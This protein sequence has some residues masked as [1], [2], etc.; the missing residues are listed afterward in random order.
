[1]PMNILF[2]GC[3]VVRTLLLA[4]RGALQPSVVLQPLLQS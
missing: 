3:F 1:L 2:R 4:T